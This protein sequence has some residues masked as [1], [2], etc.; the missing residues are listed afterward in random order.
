MDQ[1][2][3]ECMKTTN[4]AGAA[5]LTVADLARAASLRQKQ[6]LD[7]LRALVAIESP[8]A[9][10]SAV[11]R[12]MQLAAAR[13]AEL[14]GKVRWHRQR[15]YG[16]VLEARFPADPHNR[17][18]ADRS[19]AKSDPRP[20][21]LL[22]H[23]DTVWPLGTLA[24]MPF[25][26][27]SGRVF[28]PGALDMKAGVA[29]AL[30]ALS[31]L[32]ERRALTRP[33]VL[34]LNSDEEVGSPISRPITEA[35]AVKCEAVFVLEPGQGADGAYKT[36]RKGTGDYIVRVKGV[37]AHAGV[38][39]ASGHSAVLELARQ[40]QIVAAFTGKEQGLTVNPGVIGGGT[41]PNVVAAEAWA[42]VDFRYARAAHA[43]K[44]ER[45]FRELR[46]IDNNCA[47]EAVGG[48]NRPPMERTKE[49]ARLFAKAAT[50]AAELGF[51]LQEATTGGGSDGN[52]TSAIGV[53]TLD[54]MG[55]VGEGAHANNE[56]ILI[57]HLAPRTALLAAM[58]AGL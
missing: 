52:F 24:R 19:E 31:L 42:H 49:T 56:S 5:P 16:D 47:V 48:V 33:V 54:G 57:E 2:N 26:I 46:P 53:P 7:L 41:L 36:S 38:D 37:A 30:S 1:R 22:G 28:G 9:D 6:T 29:M 58:I 50:L 21:L 15:A 51:V 17:R 3:E 34:L 55:A 35:V 14:G 18:S 10:K 45:F 8:S 40:I 20:L 39:F 13:C 23:L 12:C 4:K 43:R 32:R 44:I 25:K 11:D 27:K